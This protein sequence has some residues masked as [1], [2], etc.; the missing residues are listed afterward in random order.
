MSALQ[1]T[2]IT[3]HA[4]LHD[5]PPHILRDH[6]DFHINVPVV[7]DTYLKLEM[8]I[9]DATLVEARRFLKG[10]RVEE[11]SMRP[12]TIECPDGVQA[13]T[14][15]RTRF[16]GVRLAD[17]AT[18][19]A[20]QRLWDTGLDVGERHASRQ[21]WFEAHVDLRLAPSALDPYATES[22]A[23]PHDPYATESDSDN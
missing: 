4:V 11:A 5:P 3:V 18:F 9:L 19:A 1:P 7:F 23:S 17:A 6:F 20:A 13:H 15:R 10:A 16:H 14:Y 21:Y 2:H 8:F 22:D 12:V